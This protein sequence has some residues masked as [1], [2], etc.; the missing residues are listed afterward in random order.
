MKTP[1]KIDL[2]SV[3]NGAKIG[4]HSEGEVYFENGTAYIE[5]DGEDNSHTC[6]G[7]CPDLVTLSRMGGGD[8][9]MILEEGKTNGF[10][11]NTPEGT[12]TLRASAKKIRSKISD[13]SIM[14]WLV[15]GLGISTDN[16]ETTIKLKCEF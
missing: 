5:F 9:T 15:Y 4:L 12:L 11:L 7:I 8:Y 3:Q 10:D 14:L 16:I 6:I 1:A 13:N 2:T